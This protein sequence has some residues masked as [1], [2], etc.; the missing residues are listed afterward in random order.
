MALP[1][2]FCVYSICP[3]GS[4]RIYEEVD[5]SDKISYGP[6]QEFFVYNTKGIM[7]IFT[8]IKL[9]FV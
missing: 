1:T 3:N 7:V 9:L 4:A 8:K 6:L 5:A 2:Q